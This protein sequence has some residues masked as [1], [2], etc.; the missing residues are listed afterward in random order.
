[1]DGTKPMAGAERH[2]VI[3]LAPR[4]RPHVLEEALKLRPLIE[5]TAEVVA[6]D[7]EFDVD[8]AKVDAELAIVF[9]GDGS[10]I[11]AARM[12]GYRQLPIVGVNF[13]RLGFLADLLPDE[14]KKVWPQICRREYR[15]V[16]HLMFEA[17]VFRDGKLLRRQLGL[18]ETSI[19]A[20]APFKMLEV[21]LAVDGEWVTS[22]TCDGLI[23][24]TPVGSTAHSLS[25]GGPILRQNMQAFVIS[26]ISPHTLTNRPIVDA[27]SRSYELTVA[28]PNESTSVVVDGRI[29]CRLKPGD[30]VRVERAEP[31]FKL[32]QVPGRSY[33]RTLRE[34]LGWGGTLPRLQRTDPQT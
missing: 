2:R 17:H 8:M 33:Y 4:E 11:R 22:Y 14:F 30:R 10:I 18:N 6:F 31:T 28:E 1:M 20:G 23:L 25:A 29:L 7:S 32:V 15:I 9:G 13:G 19:V 26:P 16:K 21:A 5:Q 12:M 24:S 34:K 3:L 27:A